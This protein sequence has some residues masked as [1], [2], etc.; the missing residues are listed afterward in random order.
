MEEFVATAWSNGTTACGL[1]ISAADRDRY[2]KREWRWVGLLIPDEPEPIPVNIDKKSMWDGRCRELIH[3]KIRDWFIQ[4]GKFPWPKGRPP[5][6]RLV[7]SGP[8]SFALS[9]V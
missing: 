1:K 5:R 3:I 4:S 7:Q 2:L 6:V 8:R 9:F